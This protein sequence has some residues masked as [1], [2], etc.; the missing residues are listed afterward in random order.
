MT[1][2]EKI[3]A[4]LDEHPEELTKTGW[5]ANEELRKAFPQVNR[6]TV[7]MYKNH[8]KKELDAKVKVPK[9]QIEPEKSNEEVEKQ[10][11]E[12]SEEVKK[13][14]LE[15]KVEEKKNQQEVEETGFVIKK[16]ILLVVIP[17]I[18]FIIW[19]IGR[20]KK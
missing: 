14:I 17:L 18:L 12:D 20:P 16:E 11:Q 10:N 7:S 5:G 1:I 15:K 9:P 6:K 3:Y 2:K 4:W 8:Y 19:L 13:E